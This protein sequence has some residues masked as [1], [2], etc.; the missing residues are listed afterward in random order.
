M[1]R[2]TVIKL[3]ALLGA[4]AALIL[5]ATASA[6]FKPYSLVISP[7]SPALV[8][9]GETVT[10]TA[11]IHNENTTQQLGS[12]D[13]MAPSGFTVTAAS[14]PAPATAT[15]AAKC[16]LTDQNGHKQNGPCVELRGLSLPAGGT[17][18]VTM[19]VQTPACVAPGSSWL[20]LAEFKQANDFSGQPGNDLNLDTVTSSPT[21]T[22]DGACS[23]S[24]STEPHNAVIGQHI[25]GTDWDPTG[26]AVAVQVLDKNGNLVST[27]T[28]QVT[29]GLIRNP[30]AATLSG[31][32]MQ[33]ASGGT[34][35]FGDLSLNLPG[36]PYQLGATSG[37]LTSAASSGFATAT[38]DTACAANTSC[39]TNVGNGGGSG[40]VLANA[41]P[42]SGL[43]LE[44]ANENSGA[45]LSCKGYSSADPNTYSFLTTVDRSKVLTITIVDPSA[46][47]SGSAQKILKGQMICF[48][49]PYDFTTAAGTPA[50]AGTLPDGTSGFVGLLPNCSGST[51]GPCAD[52]K[53][54]TT[55]PDPNSPLG[56][57]I[58]LVADI[59]SGLAGDPWGR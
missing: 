31:T 5:A 41:G 7:K 51:T 42:G 59:P 30:G 45:Q 52:T 12:G 29:V 6:A 37:T 16:S 49:A 15:P 23:L 1:H 32:L 53:S 40:K 18:M 54:E 24:F 11:T 58:V 28:A 9:G 2:G 33:S 20:W 38:T 56:F 27:S 46:H 3:V 36:S 17:V 14:V 10:L 50:P 22:L 57:D 43:L 55:V 47:L 44:S 35:S 4:G 25:T 21:T 8:A 13:V 48:G 39:T 34:A 19:T 26:P